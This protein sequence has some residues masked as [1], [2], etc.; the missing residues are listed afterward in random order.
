MQNA[1]LTTPPKSGRVSAWKVMKK[2]IMNA[3]VSALPTTDRGLMR[4]RV[5]AFR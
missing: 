4:L 5:G 2:R 3:A 1:R